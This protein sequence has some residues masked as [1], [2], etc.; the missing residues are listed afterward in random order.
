MSKLI[1]MVG[2][3]GSGKSTWI[4]KYIDP[5]HDVCVSRDEIRFSFLEDEDAEYFSRE[6]EVFNEYV[7]QVNEYLLMGMNVYA[8]ATH[9]NRQSRKKLLN[10][11]DF[12]N[13]SSLE[14]VVIKNN[15]NTC[16]EQNKRRSGRRLVPEEVIKSMSKSFT[17]PS[18]EEG[19]DRIIVIEG[20]KRYEIVSFDEL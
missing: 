1:L 19:F 18:P 17:I 3:P 9:L 14:A 16:L 8:D 11:V 4:Q 12:K 7:N 5:Q 13:I 10:R 6:K 20:E 15:L 2:L